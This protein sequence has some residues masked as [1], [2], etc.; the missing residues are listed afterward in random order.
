VRGMEAATIEVEAFVLHAFGA[1]AC[2]LL[3][4]LRRPG[5]GLLTG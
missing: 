1:V 2:V 5:T 3:S 4:S